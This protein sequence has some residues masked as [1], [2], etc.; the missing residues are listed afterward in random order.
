MRS[1][2]QDHHIEFHLTINEVAKCTGLTAYTLRDYERIGLIP[3]F[4]DFDEQ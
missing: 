4:L 1:I 2:F 3:N